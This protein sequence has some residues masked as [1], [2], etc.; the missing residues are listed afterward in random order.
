MSAEHC[1]HATLDHGH[2]YRCALGRFGGLPHI[3]VCRACL[4]GARDPGPRP[5]PR[6]PDD[7]DGL[8]AKTRGPCRGCRGL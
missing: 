4:A 2:T 7:P 3:G 5:A 6:D 8:D 1:Q